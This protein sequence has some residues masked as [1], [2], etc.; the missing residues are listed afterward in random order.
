MAKAEKTKKKGFV[1]K[2]MFGNEDKPD[3][4]PEQLNMSKWAMFKFI[5]FGR[6]GT[7]VLLNIL[8]LLFALPMFG[9]MLLFYLNSSVA[10]GFIPYSSNIGI[11][12]PVVSNAANLGAITDFT[13]SITEYL[14][15]I[16]CIAFFALGVAGNLYVIRKLIWQEPT[17]TIKDFFRGIK[18]CWIGAIFI[19][20]L[21]GLALLLV[22]FSAGYFDAFHLPVAYK[23]VMITVSIIL[24]VFMTIFTSFFM[25]QNAAFKMRPLA[26]L[27]NSALFTFGAFLQS[28]I[29]IGIGL[30]PVYLIFVPGIT[31][32]LAIIYV[33]IGFS[34]STIVISLFCHFCYEKFLYD[35]V[36]DKPSAVYSKRER[37]ELSEPERAKKKQPTAYKNPKKRK[38]SIDEGTSITPLT[39]TFRREDLER[40]QREHEQIMREGEEDDEPDDDETQLEQQEQPEVPVQPAQPEQP[41][42][43]DDNDEK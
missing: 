37:D 41:E 14:I 23:A 6:F 34:F 19:G 8:T 30:A 3:L 12:Y 25:T 26:L 22:V 15:L 9:V 39:P 35:K 4:T 28:I 18:K 16:P 13:Y 11:G 43:Q 42:Q 5:F 36:T 20:L 33:F 21:F 29:F 1:H 2:M 24:L 32:F 7:T 17:S 40:L 31:M 38:K 10:A 27:R